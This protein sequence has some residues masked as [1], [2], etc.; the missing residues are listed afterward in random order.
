MSD[1]QKRIIC[2]AF[3]VL[4]CV[5]PTVIVIKWLFTPPTTTQWEERIKGNLG[6]VTNVESV[7]TPLPQETILGAVHILGKENDVAVDLGSV[8]VA[9]TEQARQIVV[10]KFDVN[11]ISLAHVLRRV[12][13]EVS[14]PP[15]PVRPYQVFFGQVQ[16]RSE[17][18]NGDQLVQEL[19]GASIQ[20]L[21]TEQSLE[22]TL[23]FKLSMADDA[24]VT[25]ITY[26]RR[27]HTQPQEIWAVNSPQAEL[28]VWMLAE[29]IPELKCMGSSATFNGTIQLEKY[30]HQWNGIAAGWLKS[31]DLFHLVWLPF[32]QWVFGQADIRIDS[33][34]IRESKI[35][36]MEGD[37]TSQRGEVGMMLLHSL[38]KHLNM[39][40]PHPDL[41]PYKVR[42]KQARF[43]F[44]IEND[45][46][47]LRGDS[48]GCLIYSEDNKQ[49]LIVDQG[50]WFPIASLV[51]A[52]GD[53]Q[54]SVPLSARSMS[55]FLHVARNESF[56][57]LN[58]PYTGQA[59]KGT[60][61]GTFF[62]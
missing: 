42:Y 26:I 28:P 58:V 43:D 45:Q 23:K 25:Q 5:V 59:A 36:S 49:L 48:G 46:F 38:S 7:E 55:R 51:N 18:L 3:F 13:R 40:K 12:H 35:V 24:P 20:I 11:D 14:D 61:Q 17:N 53:H 19:H 22:L 29:I 6:L 31:V 32:D 33:C 50:A 10:Q 62:E 1:H 34:N 37:F 2:R 57:L 27:L 47:H 56:P 8:T 52:L 54:P 44:Q 4:L 16:I 30:E 21:P 39:G 15:Y 41:A 60:E 9:N